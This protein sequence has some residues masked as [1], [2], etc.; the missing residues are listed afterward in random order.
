MPYWQSPT[1]QPTP[2]PMPHCLLVPRKVH[3]LVLPGHRIDE[4][5]LF[6][7]SEVGFPGIL[8]LVISAAAQWS[9]IEFSV[10]DLFYTSYT[11]TTMLRN[12]ARTLERRSALKC[13]RV[14]VSLRPSFITGNMP[15]HSTNVRRS[16]SYAL[17]ADSYQLLA[18]EEKTGSA[19]DA[20]FEKEIE[21]VKQWWTTERYIGIRR[22]YSAEDVVSKRGTLQQ[23]YPSSLMARKLFHLFR[24]K[25]AA[26]EPVHTSA[27]SSRTIGGSRTDG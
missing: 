26:R 15:S 3:C 19:E 22:P 21:D 11:H 8:F 6:N 25:A 7:R 9:N 16:G 14:G 12:A 18:T 27:S 5:E 13:S 10:V 23:S 24:D 1:A 4:L 17:P 20:L 2:R